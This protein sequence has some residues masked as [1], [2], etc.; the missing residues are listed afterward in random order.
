MTGSLFD[1]SP[2]GTIQ[3]DR[4]DVDRPSW[5]HGTKTRRLDFWVMACVRVESFVA[6]RA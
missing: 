3:W 1:V 2:P 5:S 4:S 6:L